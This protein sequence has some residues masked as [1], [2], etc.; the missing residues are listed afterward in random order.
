VV[1]GVKA[2]SNNC[3]GDGGADE[4]TPLVVGVNEDDNQIRD[5]ISDLES[6]G[7]QDIS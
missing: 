5:G 7:R 1:R 6:T 3:E 4:T 2:S